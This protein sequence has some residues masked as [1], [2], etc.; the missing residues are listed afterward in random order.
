MALT[1]K[2]SAPAFVAYWHFASVQT[3][4]LNGRFRSEA[5][6]ADVWRELSR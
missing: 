2:L 1:D 5:D 3:H 6:I 4:G